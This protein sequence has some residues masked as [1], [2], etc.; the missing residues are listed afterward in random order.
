M[1]DIGSSAKVSGDSARAAGAPEPGGAAPDAA[2]ITG[3]AGTM[4]GGA[5]LALAWDATGSV[6]LG[7]EPADT[8]TRVYRGARGD[9]RRT[10]EYL[11]ARGKLPI[12]NLHD[13][14]K[15]TPDKAIP[16]IMKLAAMSRT[17]A[18]RE[19]RNLQAELL[20][21][22]AARLANVEGAAGLAEAIG[23]GAAHYLAASHLSRTQSER[24][25]ASSDIREVSGGP[26]V[27]DID[28]EIEGGATIVPMRSLPPKAQD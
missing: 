19:W 12:E 27:L 14:A 25:V 20:P 6:R 10:T 4:R 5:Q 23:A 28:G 3:A 9:W 24:N 17:E 16:R 2:G 1:S 22:T 13:L 21:Y 8:R 11:A 26:Q 15:L 18:Y 7:V